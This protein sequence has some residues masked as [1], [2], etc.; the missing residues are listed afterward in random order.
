MPP[1]P[2][3]DPAFPPSDLEVNVVATGDYAAVR[4]A[5]ASRAARRRRRRPSPAPRAR[6]RSARRRPTSI[7]R[8]TA[9]ASTP[10]QRE[11]KQLA[12]VDVPGDAT[13][14]RRRDRRSRPTRRSARSCCRATA[15]AALLYTNATARR[16]HHA[17]QA[18]PARLSARDV[19][20]QE[21]ACARS[22]SRRRRHR[23]R[24]ATR[25]RSAIP[26]TATIVDDYIDKSYGYTLL[27]L[28]SG[29]A[30]C[31]SRRSIRARSRTRPTAR[32]PTSRLDGGDAATATRALQ[33]VTTQTGVVHHRSR[34]ARRRRRSASCPA[35]TQAF[36]AQRHPL[37]RVSFVDLVTD[38]V[39]TV[40]GF[41][42]NSHV[43]QLRT[44][45]ASSSRHLLRRSPALLGRR[46]PDRVGR[47]IAPCSARSR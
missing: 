42:L 6:S 22:A 41:D 35:P 19:A 31:R 2:V 13:I 15:R 43:V 34:S 23:D 30:S 46:A 8:P 36:V 24:A 5:G 38:A 32:R 40:T 44:P 9:R 20:A 1:I 21:G 18:R 25:R 17:G 27:D 29:F 26:A 7:S 11:A 28:A 39:R 14:R 16:A 33:I 12:I 10:S 3:A 37:G 45:C 47:A 4:Q